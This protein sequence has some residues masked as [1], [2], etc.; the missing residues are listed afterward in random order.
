MA[1]SAFPFL[2]EVIATGN[3]LLDGTTADTN[4]QRLALVLRAYG[5]KI[6]R[7][8]V[9]ADDPQVISRALAE[10]S[11]R[12]NLVVVSGG[13]GPTT[14]DITLDVAASTFG[15]PMVENALAKKNVLDRLKR[16]RRKANPGNLK[17]AFIPKGA[18]VLKNPEG[19]APG[20][21]WTVGQCQFFFLPG[22]PREFQFILEH[23]IR[24]VVAKVASIER[25]YLF[26]TGVFGVPESEMSEWV[27]TLSLPRNIYVGFR[28]HLPENY[29]KWDIIERSEKRARATA[30]KLNKICLKKFG[31]KVF[32]LQGE[33]FGESVVQTLIRQRKTVALAESCT[34]GLAS[35]MLTSVS[36]S[37]AVFQR[38]YVV[39]SNDSKVDLLGVSEKTLQRY[40]AVSEETAI[41]M[42][43]GARERAQ[44]DLAVSITG[45]AGPSG[46]T[47]QKPVGTVWLAVSSSKGVVTRRLQLSFTRELNKNFQ[48]I[49]RFSF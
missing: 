30:A 1:Q 22:V 34:G 25:Q 24:P 48:R 45:V 23:S 8:T 29:I 17:Q 11:V 16:I 32:S 49:G 28:T 12:S 44:V 14:D 33:S 19:T 9:I 15:V 5:L 6:H 10:A 47:R 41:E 18:K 27:K 43:V 46:G 40:G 37:S 20:V 21:E 3:E 13:L 39:Y 31:S 38:G 7:T 26:P 35:S 36:G 2:I 4:T 42:A